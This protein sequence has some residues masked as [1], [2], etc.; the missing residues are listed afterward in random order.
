YLPMGERTTQ[1]YGQTGV[2]LPRWVSDADWAGRIVLHSEKGL[3][4]RLPGSFTTHE[5]AG[6]AFGL[7]VSTPE[8]AILEWIALT[9][10]AL[11]FGDELVDTFGGLNTLRPRRLQALLQGCRSVRT[12]RAFLVL[13]RHA[14]HAWYQRLDPRELDLGKGKRQLFQGGKLDRQYHVTVPEAFVH[15]N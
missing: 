10:N 14:G 7:Q 9:P 8:R 1:L 2:R 12:K 13:A 3:P 5:P 6:R 4:V 15:A 11:L